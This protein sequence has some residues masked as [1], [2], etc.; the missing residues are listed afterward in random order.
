MVYTT[1]GSSEA[2]WAGKTYSEIRE[3]GEKNGSIAIIPTSSVEQHGNHLPVVVDTLLV[4]AVSHL[5]AERA[6]EN[7]DVPVLVTPPIWSGFSPHHMSFGGTLTIGLDTMQDVIRDIVASTLDNGFDAVLLLNGHGGNMSIISSL[8]QEL[9][10]NNP[11]VEIL[12]LTYF[13]LASAFI[14]EYRE[15]KK[16]GMSHAG[17]FET[18][19]VMHLRPELVREDL[20]EGTPREAPY[21]WGQKDMFDR[22][23]LSVGDPIERRTTTGAVGE[24]ETASEEKGEKIYDDLGDELQGLLVRVHDRNQ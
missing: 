1:I 18:S 13:Q 9:G 5:G 7:N 14:D 8:A 16:G 23:S 20:I 17:E 21:P 15:T 22:G 4:D 10:S 11:D 6:I 12:A 19:L 2:D 3:I 24:P